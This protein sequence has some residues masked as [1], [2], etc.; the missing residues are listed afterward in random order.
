MREHRTDHGGAVNSP[1][2]RLRGWRTGA[3]ALVAI[4]ST[5]V[6]V[7]A[8][9][10]PAEAGGSTAVLEAWGY[11][12]DGQLGNGT[13]TNATTPTPVH[14]PSG[15]T[16]TASAA[17]GDSSLAI[18]SDG[19]LYAWGD[20]ASGQLGNGTTNNSS[21]PVVV[22]LPSGVHATAIAAGADDSI[23]LGS[24]GN[25][26]AWGDNTFDE[27]GNNTSV[28]DSTTPV[29]VSIPTGVTVTAIAAGQYHNLALT[30]AGA[31]YAWGYNND[32][33]L[34]DAKK[35]TPTTPVLVSLPT[36]VKA[37]AIAAGG[38]HSLAAASNGDV[39]AWGLNADGQLGT[40]TTTTET[41]PTVVSMPSG[42]SATLVAAGLY[43][44]LAV[45]SNGKLYSW[46][47]NIYGQLGIGSETESKTPVAVTLP[48]GATPTAIAAGLYYSA[49]LLPSGSMYTFG[50]NDLGQLGN[51]TTNNAESP[52]EVSAPAN[53]TFTGLA[54][55]SSS[56][57]TLAIDVPNQATTT[58][59][60]SPSVTS[61]VYGTAE[62]L[63]ATVSGS[64]GG[65]SVSFM[66]GATALSG[67]SSVA[68][69][70]SGSNQQA[71]C[72]V[73]TL[74]AGVSDLTAVY[75]GDGASLGSTSSVL[76]LTVTPAPLT[77]TASSD[78]ETY[79]IAPAAITASY[80]GF[81]L[82]QSSS[83]LSTLPTCTTSATASSPAGTYSSS[84]SGAA[85]PNYSISYVAGN[86][87]VAPSPL[88]IAASTGSMTYGG[89]APTITPTYSGFV[90]GDTVASLT[91]QPVCTTTATS[92]SPV[93]NY[94]SSCSGASDPN[95]TISYTVG[96][97]SVGA[98]EL[99]ITASSVATTYGTAAT[100]I[101]PVYSG[102]VNGDTAESL[103]TAPTCTNAA[104]LSSP[105]G[106]YTT[107]C[108]GASDPNYTISYV[109][110]TAT[111]TPAPLAITASSAS[112]TYGGSVPTISAIVNGL[113]NG[114]GA[115]VLG[116]DLACSTTA[117][118]GSAV[119]SY[120]S[121]CS[122]AS[123][124]N[125]AITYFTGNVSVT[126][127]LLTVTASSGSM[128]YGGNVPTI[129]AAIDGFQNGDGV[130]ALGAGFG[131][132]TTATPASPVGSYGSSCSGAS[133]PDYT[134]DYVSGTVTD[135]PADISISA[136]SSSMSYGSQ[137][138]AIEPIV[139]GLQ[140]G[141]GAAVLGAGLECSTSAIPSSPVG[142]YASMC[143]G[144]VDSDY[145][146][147][148]IEGTVS[149]DPDPL[150]VTA[151]SGTTGYGSAVPAVTAS[152]SGFVNG[153]S[154]ASLT[155]QPVCTTDASAASPVGSYTTSCSG[156]AD[157]NYTISYAGGSD[158]IIQD[159]LTITASS[160]STTYGSAVP[161]V[162]ASYSGF[163]NGDTSD[164]LTTQPV[165]TT[166][167]SS[168][169]SVGTY[170]T[171][172]S[173]AADPNYTIAYAGGS[174]QV[175][176]A[177]LTITASSASTNYGS[178]IAPVTASYSGFANGD[179]ADSLTTQPVCTT[180]ATST[181]PAGAYATSCSGAADPNYTITYEVG[182]DLIS[183]DVLTI[184]ASSATT[185]YGSAIAPVTAS[186]SGFVNGDTAD[187]LTTQPVC[188][189]TASASSPVGSYTTSCSGAADP[190]YTIDYVNGTDAIGTDVLTITASSAATAYGSAIAPVTAS[191]SGFVNGDT[192]A[193]LTA[194]PVCTTDATASS[195]VGSYT[196][197]C[198]GATDPNYTI[199]Y[200]N[201]SDAINPD[202]L[203]VTA[204][205]PS[206]IYGSPVPDISASYTGFV[207]GDTAASLTTQ[208]VC[209]T[210]ATGSSPA[211][212]YDTS[213]TDASDPN[214]TITYEDGW[215][216]VGQASLSVL[217]SSASVTY[218]DPTPTITPT[219]TGFVN[220]DTAASLT[221]QAAC[222]TTY[223]ATSPVGSYDT[224]CSGASDPNY[225]I[226]YLDGSVTVGQAS[227]SVLA[228]S[229][230][231][232]YGDPTPTITPTYTGFVAGD[233]AASLTAQPVCTTTDSAS[234]PVGSYDTSCS[235]AADPNYTITYQDGSVTVGV[236]LLDVQ[237]SSS[238]IVY[239]S[240]TPNILPIY[241]GFV[242]GDS[243]ASLT[244][245]ATCSTSVLPTTPVGSYSS[246]CSGAADAN[247]DIS[248]VEGTVDVS[249][250]SVT[251]TA[252]SGTFVF[253][254]SPPTITASVAGLQNTEL[255][256]VLVGLTCSSPVTSTSPVGAYDASCSSG[257]DS[258]YDISYV[259]GEVDV[260]AAPLQITASSN[261]FTY[262]S[263][264]PSI[265][266]VVS[267]LAPGDSVADL[268]SGLTCSS[269]AEAS[270]PVGSYPS[271]CSGAV[272]AN[273]SIAYVDGT[274][275]ELAAPLEIAASS[276]S[277]SYG[278]TPPAITPSYSGFVN[279]DGPAALTDVPDCVTDA[280]S[281]SPVGSYASSCSGASDPN[282]SISYVAGT[283]VVGTQVLTITA[284]SASSAYGSNPAAVT[285]SYSGFVN[286]DT[287]ASLTAQ[288][289]CTTTASASSPVGSYTTS[290]SGASDPNYTIAYENGDDVIT[291]N[292]LTVTASSASTNYGSAVPAVTASYSGFVNGDTA[293]SL[294]AQPVCTTTASA[295]SPV[296]SYTTSC[297]GASDPNYTIKYV[298]GSDVI[299]TVSLAITAS[300][301]TSAYGSSPAAVTAAYSGFVNGDTAAS[302]TAQ[303]V[304]TTTA[305]ASSPV[306]TYTTSCTGASDPNYTISYVTGSDV[307]GTDVLTVTASSA[308]TTYGSAVPA[309]TASY[310]GFVN[311]DTAASLT[312]QPVCTT[313]A[314]ASS[315]V[316]TYT[317]SCTGAADSNYTISYVTGS[318]VIGTASLA[319]TASSA[320][321]TYGSAVPAVTASISGFV[322][323]DTAASLTA[324]PVCTSAASASS[325][326]G[327]YTNSCSGAADSNYTISYV[328]GTDVIR[329][330]SLIITASSPST[331]YGSA[332]PAVT[333]AYSGFV[334]GDTVASLTAQPVCTTT[335]SAS[336]PVGTYTT[337]CTGAS[338]PNYTI[339][340]VTGKEAIGAAPL[341]VSASSATEVFGQ[342]PAAVTASY[343]GFV[344][345]Q[346][347]G[348]LTHLPVCTSSVSASSPVGTYAT[349]C[350]GAVDSNYTISYVAGSVHVTPAPLTITASS[351]K[352]TY[353]GTP[354]TITA[355]VTGL[356]N[357]NSVSVLGTLKCTTSVTAT[358][359]V[360]TYSS[361]C[362]GASDAN[363]TI[364][365]ASGTVTV[366]AAVLTV[367][368]NNQSKLFGQVNP[369]LTYAITGFVNGQ[370]LATSGVTGA[371]ACTTTA[372]QT[373]PAG[374]YP[375][376]C[377]PG[378][379]SATNYTFTFVA[380]TLTVS[381][382]STLSCWWF[383]D[384]D[385]WAGQS[386]RIAP[387]CWV[388]G[389][390]RVHPG[391][392]LDVEGGQ[393]SGWLQNEGGLMRVCSSNVDGL[394]S[395]VDTTNPVLIGDG[396]SD[397]GGS[398]LSGGGSF[399]SNSG[400]LSVQQACGYGLIDVEGNSG[401]VVVTDN[402]VSGSFIVRG[403]SGWVYDPFNQVNGGY[404]EFQ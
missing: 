45:G 398:T 88:S 33:Q 244:S 78:T 284:S 81:V 99:Q 91:S 160:A 257:V 109:T 285:P 119:G 193:S 162:T 132:S 61:P 259:D 348:S 145:T 124:G 248:Y 354:P 382:T 254:G 385:V 185:A 300:S 11:N 226:N 43:H 337:S 330:V 369:T 355:T 108:S 127:A 194:Q 141:E 183:A 101:T 18:G 366:S 188:T 25:V 298:T 404:S 111:V 205:S 239:G 208:P 170:A 240:A 321:T 105:V 144:A 77:V 302:L 292:V 316:G 84:C 125:Y 390:I 206:T 48:G 237:A 375:I 46:G 217:A 3:A 39:Y 320:S 266:P 66:D 357:G 267:G 147:T 20:N 52:V 126:P 97:V 372:T 247:Y 70:A 27:L 23:A 311:G 204:S 13:T 172:C 90:N 79:G 51:G 276:G 123:D 161:A 116:D 69:S 12:A 356:V 282:Y 233:T 17:G 308:S 62:T 231:V 57:H 41:S 16:A 223:S 341:V 329:S 294:T 215:A 128:T 2:G 299:G 72:T 7:G 60:L 340:Y 290:C 189:T 117:S 155:T 114:E 198:S 8:T 236:A 167:A 113:Q 4:T 383:G 82:G 387:G 322:N 136:S 176:P 361:N 344:L 220:G 314:S 171:S 179:T 221:D 263:T 192:V 312:A 143:S 400:G 245:Q 392:W 291:A 181:S 156:A 142:V 174:D 235:G 165:C 255:P 351:A 21:T 40:G 395:S 319:I 297:S 359:P 92:S 190:N 264:P 360:G 303:P 270:T 63:T 364:T 178:A 89:A 306:G 309:V 68:L 100:A 342:T 85:D 368:A 393:I 377:A 253:G 47:Y 352:M 310:S 229:A 106:T 42:V 338:D 103:L 402:N 328:T 177:S 286:G 55:D 210:T 260:T 187:S 209:T 358:S 230:S 331:T 211:G 295:S 9:S 332:V 146:I 323:G 304:C 232:T 32:G 280:T 186:Y 403:N 313:T 115:S 36:G 362:S 318:D 324:Q 200:V 129:T 384:L 196:T 98:A 242:N 219:Y 288:P 28:S 139:T 151:S 225:T 376:T 274:V 201:G 289:V 157:P 173:G 381:N 149:V 80:S 169:S 93:G 131:C 19:N 31:I 102:F 180:D 50:E 38:Y 370:T 54:T 191:Y 378:T 199:N 164:S 394:L 222:T 64:D 346:G 250:A 252:S 327:T 6:A 122:G 251:V 305:S 59:T 272:D 315:P 391:G 326:V 134:Y 135:S 273:Y 53:S 112:M 148:Y 216:T 365:Y 203:I 182:T 261:S 137:P 130:A 71:T 37:I 339:T 44:S 96:Q 380:G 83:S 345:G 269:T 58:T 76:A 74:T 241:S 287:A 94:P 386:I 281:S 73:S 293:A 67:C 234:S 246:G 379:L 175:N 350:S 166:D 207:N 238:S 243:A 296:G 277:M 150:T 343:S 5:M 258:N 317:T 30:S 367:K 275:N 22:D 14:L 158:V 87:V 56:T 110:G 349:S 335:A 140:N 118:S 133:D 256:S 336:S 24:D 1:G 153:D 212:Y 401:D 228:S 268:G 278:A 279:G 218:G 301:G 213:C 154:A 249:P 399:T 10:L 95:Y 202:S 214:Y 374:T 49:A 224:N 34:G 388:L 262:G 363:Y 371:P 107:S 26:Y 75:S 104:T 396:A 138:P 325:P 227:L 397:C 168:S 184:T 29:K 120:T 373:S 35:T 65:G 121:S 307:I 159:L 271:S 389:N 353:G 333:A 283:V 15:V 195:S 152:Y 163:V 347:S 265:T 334:N 197:S 86:V